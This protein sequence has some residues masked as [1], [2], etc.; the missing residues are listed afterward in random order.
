MSLWTMAYNCWLFVSID[1]IY[2]LS[3]LIGT[4][5]DLSRDIIRCF[6]Y[7]DIILLKAHL[8]LFRS[9]RRKYIKYLKPEMK[10]TMTIPA[11]INRIAKIA[12]GMA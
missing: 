6:Y 9:S 5:I 7:A 1:N 8:N 12:G 10:K 3:F 11:P 4:I 2:F